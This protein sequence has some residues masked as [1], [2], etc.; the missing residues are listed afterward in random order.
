MRST[1]YIGTVNVKSPTGD[2]FL[3]EIQHIAE[4]QASAAWGSIAQA[5]P[6]KIFA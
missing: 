1:V 6:A 5:G 2:G 3:A 4:R